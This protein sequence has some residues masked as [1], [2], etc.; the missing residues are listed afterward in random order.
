MKAKMIL[1]DYQIEAVEAAW[2]HVC[3]HKTNPVIVAPTGS[4][5][6]LMI[7]ELCR[8]AVEVFNGRVIVLAHRK[9]LLEQNSEKIKTLLPD[10]SIGVYSS[11]LKL[12]DTKHDIIVG[13]IQSLYEIAD[14]FGKRNLIIVDE[15]HLIP[16]DKGG[17]YSQ[18]LSECKDI[19]P[20]LRIIGLTATPY[21]L[22]D[23]NLCSEYGFLNEICYSI[24]IK[25]LVDAGWLAKLS[26]AASSLT[27]DFSNLH[28]RNGE[29]VEAEMQSVF[30]PENIVHAACT[31][32][33]H[34][35]KNRKSCLV[36]CSGVLHAEH[37]TRVIKEI[38]GESAFCV[39]GETPSLE[40][41]WA[42]RSFKNGSLKYLVNCDVLTTGFDAPNIDSIAVLRAT[43]SP[44]LFVQMLGRGMRICDGKTDCIVVDFG[45]NLRRHGPI[46]HPLYGLRVPNP[47]GTNEPP[48][49]PYK[50]CHSCGETVALAL[51][52]CECGTVL[53]D[54]PEEIARH[55]DK[56]DGESCVL[57]SDVK[58]QSWL[59]MK[60][61]L[62]RHKG[63][64]GKLDTLKVEYEC[65]P[66]D[67][68]DVEYVCH[69]C[70]HVGTQMRLSVRSG[71][72]NQNLIQ[73]SK[74]LK[75]ICK[76][77][78]RGD[79]SSRTIAEWVCIEHPGYAGTKARM[80]WAKRTNETFPQ[81]IDSAI[82]VFEAGALSTSIGITTKA[83][84]KFTK[85]IDHDIPPIVENMGS[86][87]QRICE[88]PF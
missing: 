43:A 76:D 19:N 78:S 62:T 57:M 66:E 52:V 27:L 68:G 81:S 74:C 55:G 18:F 65:V 63:K 25:P 7:A 21:R 49:G 56:A 13:G 50:N 28:I 24:E 17:M 83:D 44:G 32:I 42:L 33:C 11:G 73:C 75:E 39:V 48:E 46:D 40:R 51:K 64:E 5:K 84:G 6:S 87:Q 80:W 45:G 3:K 41:A 4:G 36:F 9:E 58:N 38:S 30:A 60:T 22:S 72:Y 12:R 70:C 88:V 35:N 1:R 67:G 61:K 8:A 20:A 85:I 82:M 29:F 86:R 14:R 54:D 31:E 10:M 71:K 59:V 79:L 37:V 16:K 2:R 53:Y 77:Y 15:C 23:G 26:A 69:H 47:K 34:V